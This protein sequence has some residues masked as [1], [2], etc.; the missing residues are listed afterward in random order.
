MKVIA[1][2]SFAVFLAI[3]TV[4]SL[5]WG[6]LFWGGDHFS[7]ADDDLPTSG[8]CGD[9]LTWT[10]DEQGTL[11]I[12]GTGKMTDFIMNQF[13][14]G[15][16]DEN[17]FT[18]YNSSAPWNI[19]NS[20]DGA[21]RIK[22]IVIEPGV[23]SIGDYAFFKCSSL[24]SIEI[25]D[26]VT[27]IGSEAFWD[28]SAL[29][30][31]EIPDSVTSIGSTA[32]VSCSALQSIE[33][34]DSV[35]SIGFAAFMECTS[36]KSIRIP[37]SVTSI[38]SITFRL[39]RSLESV[40]IPDGVT[41]I[42]SSAFADCISLQSINIPDSVTSIGDNAFA[43]CFSLQSIEIPDSV[44]S[45]GFAAFQLC[46]SLESIEIPDSVTSIED[47]T[48]EACYSLQSIEIPNSVTSIGYIAFKDCRELKSI[49]IPSSVTSIGLRAFE[50]CNVLTDIYYGG[51][52]EQWNAINGV[53]SADIPETTTIH[54]NS[55][56]PDQPEVT[57]E[58][59]AL[60]F[61]DSE[62]GTKIT[63]SGKLKL[64]VEPSNASKKD[65]VWTSSDPSIATVNNTGT[66]IALKDGTVTITVKTKDGKLSSSIKVEVI[67][68]DDTPSTEDK[69][70]DVQKNDWFFD[71]V[72]WAFV[73]GI[74]EGT[75]ETTF[76]PD[77]ECTRSQIVTFLWRANGSPDIAVSNQFTDVSSDQYYAKAVAW[78]VQQGI[79]AGTSDTTFS[80]DMPCT[81]AQAVTFLW[82]ANESPGASASSKFNDVDS[83]QYYAK[84]VEWAV[85]QG[86]TV[87]TS[88]TTFSPDVVC[89]RAQ[90]VTFIYRAK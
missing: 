10:L 48:F 30:S 16:V 80:P 57:V 34:P 35:T 31:I 78:A 12:S 90:I 88:D 76:S 38:S 79:T 1:K 40:N 3:V 58:P 45:I 68:S 29:K 20:F 65:L 84:A 36:L 46:S 33:I 71:A 82:R 69:F 17:G 87:G 70:T 72:Y 54:Y 83:S 77:N 23:T 53:D 73:E 37:D 26:G 39:C 74:A 47:Q 28:C 9:N 55:T 89:T 85:Q 18:I 43:S 4:L 5:S 60:T 56:M 61:P 14:D 41:S 27:S 7:Y 8:T 75:S 2:R 32:F 50:A 51:T 63:N 19:E 42:D 21:A 62:S 59:T 86:I 11:T 66:V 22:K 13:E 15:S 64:T 49:E 81:R 6:G 52:E 67:K 25:P 44:T 24:Q